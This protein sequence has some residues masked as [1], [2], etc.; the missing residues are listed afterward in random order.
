MAFN[1]INWMN[2]SLDV[3]GENERNVEN[4]DTFLTDRK[5]EME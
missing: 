5:C 2:C 1:E 3:R 4:S